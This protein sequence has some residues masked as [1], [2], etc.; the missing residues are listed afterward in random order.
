VALLAPEE[1][2]DAILTLSQDHSPRVRAAVATALAAL[3]SDR[4]LGALLQLGQ[5]GS[6]EVRQAATESLAK[7]STDDRAFAALLERAEDASLEVVRSAYGGLVESRRREALAF[8]ISALAD[9]RPS[10]APDP[11]PPDIAGASPKAVPRAALANCALRWLT[12]QDFGWHWRASGAAQEEARKRWQD[13]YDR[14]GSRADL[15]RVSPPKGV[16]TYEQLL[17]QAPRP[18]GRR[19]SV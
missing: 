14:E 16:A 4:A 15:T 12:G 3:P 5:D 11:L 18:Q 6:A 19:L 1:H 8:F 2:A 10:W 17:R 7:R 13:W 9:E